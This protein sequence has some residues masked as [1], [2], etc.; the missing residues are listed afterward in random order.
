MRRLAVSAA[1]QSFA[2]E[3][4]EALGLD[5]ARVFKT[6]VVAADAGAEGLTRPA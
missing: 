3:A 6:L 4:A 1:R 5:P 2:L